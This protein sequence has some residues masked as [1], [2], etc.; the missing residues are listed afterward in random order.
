MYWYWNKLHKVALI[1]E[2]WDNSL[3][4][5]RMHMISR[6]EELKNE[7]II[8]KQEAER[9]TL[10]CTEL[11]I[12]IEELKKKV[13][14]EMAKN[15]T[16]KESDEKSQKEIDDLKTQNEKSKKQVDFYSKILD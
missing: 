15:K 1:G 11:K 6:N 2:P 14:E 12:E 9:A 7:A 4:V 3:E 8:S 10:Q 5:A 16:L 13:E